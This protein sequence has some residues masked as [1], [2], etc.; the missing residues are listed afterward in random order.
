MW[1]VCAARSPP[2]LTSTFCER[3][4]WKQQQTNNVISLIP[5]RI[6]S[7]LFHLPYRALR[8][9]DG[10]GCCKTTMQCEAHVEAMILLVLESRDNCTYCGELLSLRSTITFILRQHDGHRCATS[11]IITNMH[12]NHINHQAWLLAWA[13]KYILIRIQHIEPNS[14]Y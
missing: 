7:D 11:S 5:P 4:T 10:N 1:Y 2:L 3:V 13:E 12:H 6:C 9:C 14:T 8:S